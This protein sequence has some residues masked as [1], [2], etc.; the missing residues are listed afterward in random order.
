MSARILVNR[1]HV[2]ARRSHPHER[3][4][5]DLRSR[6]GALYTR[7]GQKTVKLAADLAARALVD[8]RSR[9][10]HNSRAGN[11]LGAIRARRLG[12]LGPIR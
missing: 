8:A 7:P 10:A 4:A 9:N 11:D 6:T 12:G 1:R 2:G 3:T 5:Y